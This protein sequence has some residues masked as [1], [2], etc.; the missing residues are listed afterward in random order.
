MEDLLFPEKDTPEEVAFDDETLDP[1][2]FE[3]EEGL[4]ELDFENT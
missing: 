3:D 2:F 1:D 4:K